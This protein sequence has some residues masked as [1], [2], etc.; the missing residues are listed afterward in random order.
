MTTHGRE[1][2]LSTT[3][4]C[5]SP[6]ESCLLLSAGKGTAAVQAET[7]APP[8]PPWQTVSAE[9]LALGQ[10]ITGT[11]CSRLENGAHGKWILARVLHGA[12]V[13]SLGTAC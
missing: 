7:V 2:P 3:C 9:V 5:S 12:F 11:Q 1:H 13:S 8:W 10:L 6:K 4:L